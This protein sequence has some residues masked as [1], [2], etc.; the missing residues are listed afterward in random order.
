MGDSR[1]QRIENGTG[2]GAGDWVDKVDTIELYKA[3]AD[4]AKAA[5]Q[6]VREISDLLPPNS[7]DQSINP[8][9]EG[10][11]GGG[12]GPARGGPGGGDGDKSDDKGDGDG[13]DVPD[14][15]GEVD[16]D[17][18]VDP[19]LKDLGFSIEKAK[20][21]PG[22]EYWKLVS[23]EYED[24]KES[25]GRHHVYYEVVDEQ[26]R[27]VPG[28]VVTQGWP[29]G[30]AKAG[31]DGLG[32]ANIPMYGG[33]KYNPANGEKGPYSAWVD[34]LPSDKAQGMGLPNGGHVN[35]RLKYQRA[36]AK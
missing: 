5:L 17:V 22:E 33:G 10:T 9:L 8:S 7:Q 36:I 23:V 34:G 13:G 11:G 6:A 30:S 32:G 25:G 2:S 19:R 31:A 26:G 21:K 29:T 24:Y 3:A 12:S 15:S 4:M 16:E 1:W 28:A 20:V 14:D 18:Y 35:Y 27:P